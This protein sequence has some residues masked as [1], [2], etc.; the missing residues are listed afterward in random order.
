MLTILVNTNKRVK[1]IRKW[2]IHKTKGKVFSL[3]K[4]RVY[5][6]QQKKHT[7]RKIKKIKIKIKKK[8]L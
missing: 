4:R 5:Y 8:F 1:V 6:K 3:T 2:K 7:C